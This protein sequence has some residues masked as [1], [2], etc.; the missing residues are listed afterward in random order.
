[1]GAAAVTHIAPPVYAEN[2]RPKAI[3]QPHSCRRRGTLTPGRASRDIR[4]RWRP[5]TDLL[6]PRS[7]K[8]EYR[9]GRSRR[10]R[11]G[12]TQNKI[13]K[14]TQFDPFFSTKAQ[15]ESQIPTGADAWRSTAPGWLTADR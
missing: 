2:K 4:L 14:R 5:A 15:N 9:S 3:R 10:G 11:L 13:T 8:S 7:L 6:C 1:M 12:R